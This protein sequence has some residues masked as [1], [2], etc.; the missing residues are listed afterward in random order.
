MIY[1]N[2][3]GI[4]RI[5][6]WNAEKNWGS[7]DTGWGLFLLDG[8]CRYLKEYESIVEEN[9]DTEDEF[10]ERVAG[11]PIHAYRLM[12]RLTVDWNN[13]KNQLLHDQWQ[14]HCSLRILFFLG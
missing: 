4:F 11:N 14:G 12:K 8:Y 9:A 7:S 2:F 6:G 1:W 13:I 3:G 10:M 5:F